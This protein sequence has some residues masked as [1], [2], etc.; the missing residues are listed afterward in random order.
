MYIIFPKGRN[1]GIVRKYYI[2][3]KMK[4]SKVNSKSRDSISD[5][6][7]LRWL[8]LSGFGDYNTI[9][10]LGLIPFLVYSPP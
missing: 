2:K 9:L 4:P 7:G 3:A 6:G 5:V 1:W 8:C 10:S